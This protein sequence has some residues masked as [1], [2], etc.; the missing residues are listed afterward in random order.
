MILS[1]G[2]DCQEVALNHVPTDLVSCL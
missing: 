2:S 1:R